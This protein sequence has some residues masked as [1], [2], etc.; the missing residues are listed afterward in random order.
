[1]TGRSADTSSGRRSLATVGELDGPVGVGA[2][3][4]ELIGVALTCDGL[5][6][7]P[8]VV[9][10]GVDPLQP[11]PTVTTVAESRARSVLRRLVIGLEHNRVGAESGVNCPKAWGAVVIVQAEV[12]ATR[13]VQMWSVPLTAGDLC[14]GDCPDPFVILLRIVEEPL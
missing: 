3:V 7:G 13:V 11:V 14:L 5:A 12:R 4:P 9:R 6:L 1:M 10:A 2:D 8:G